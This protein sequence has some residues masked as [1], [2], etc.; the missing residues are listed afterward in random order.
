VCGITR[1]RSDATSAPLI[2]GRM[3][4]AHWHITDGR[5]VLG[6]FG[7]SRND[8]ECRAW[9]WSFSLVTHPCKRPRGTSDASRT[10]EKRSTIDFKPQS[11]LTRLKNSRAA[12]IISFITMPS[13]PPLSDL[14]IQASTARVRPKV[15]ESSQDASLK[16]KKLRREPVNRKITPKQFSRLIRPMISSFVVPTTVRAARC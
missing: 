10:S 6:I 4:S 2:S 5:L 11:Q 12:A 3:S 14:P 1:G 8:S 9:G 7:V 13:T 15:L 16:A